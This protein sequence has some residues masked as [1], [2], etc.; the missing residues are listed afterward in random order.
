MTK[1]RAEGKKAMQE[2]GWRGTDF[3]VAMNEL[4]EEWIE[5]CYGEESKETVEY[6]KKGTFRRTGSNVVKWAVAATL[7]I[8][9]CGGGVAY[10]AKLGVLR[11]TRIND[12]TKQGYSLRVEPE[13][14]FTEELTG[15]I[16]E[17]EKFLQEY[18][19]EEEYRQTY[20]SWLKKFE[21][22]EMARAYI[23]YE[24]FK[25][26]KV[27]GTME[28]VDVR[29][30]GNME[31]K[32]GEVSLFV[33]YQEGTISLNE[34][35]AVFTEQ[36]PL[37]LQGTGIQS[38]EKNGKKSKY[39]S[40]EYITESG[41]TAVFVYEEQEDDGNRSM[42]VALVD[43]AVYYELSVLYYLQDFERAKELM[44]QWCEQF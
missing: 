33:R 31:G 36:C 29:V 37:T 44:V 12:K 25:E 22:V 8:L 2:N 5:G 28:A 34:T 20:P 43:G 9:L 26:T 1:K 38:A 23:G 19:A 42:V 27:P 40:E 18:M 41:K 21:T 17:V 4:P 14:I 39:R 35:A 32:L 6:G 24:G 3:L 13:R 16:Q 15:E 30:I 10:A 11:F 7:A